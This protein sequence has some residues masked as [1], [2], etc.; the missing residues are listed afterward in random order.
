MIL[1]LLQSHKPCA[2]SGCT[3]TQRP[4]RQPDEG[5]R[6]REVAVSLPW[7]QVPTEMAF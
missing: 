5:G 1:V 2:R 7:R 4:V 6:G 3:V